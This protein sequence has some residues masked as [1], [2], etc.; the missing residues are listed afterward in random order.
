[1]SCPLWHERCVVSEDAVPSM[2]EQCRHYQKRSS[3]N[4]LTLLG[5]LLTICQNQISSKSAS[6]M[7][8]KSGRLH[9]D[10]SKEKTESRGPY[11]TPTERPRLW[12]DSNTDSTALHLAQGTSRIEVGATPVWLT[13]SALGMC[14][15][16]L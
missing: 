2:R 16:H 15:F 6:F 7:S 14:Y 11:T 8:S 12:R 10:T 3:K 9:K 5:I 4:V 13:C 1:M